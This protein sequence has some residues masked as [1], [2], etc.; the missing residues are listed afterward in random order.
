MEK[1]NE[2]FTAMG[3]DGF[4]DMIQSRT[5]RQLDRLRTDRVDFVE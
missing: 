2:Q 5:Q 3:A 1:L 4:V